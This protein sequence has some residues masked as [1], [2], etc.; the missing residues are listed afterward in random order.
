MRKTLIA[1]LKALTSTIVLFGVY[2]FLAFLFAY[3]D[4]GL[5]VRGSALIM[6]FF[7]FLHYR[8]KAKNEGKRDPEEVNRKSR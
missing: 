5:V 4:R 2:Y 1:C 6:F 7:F 3:E 8:H